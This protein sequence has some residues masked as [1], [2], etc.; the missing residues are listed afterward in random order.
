MNRNRKG[1]QS[2]QTTIRAWTYDQARNALP[3][4]GS[5][6]SS[7]R[8]HWLDAQHFDRKL[9]QLTRQPGRPDRKRILSQEDTR[10]QAREALEAFRNAQEELNELDVFCTDPVRGE[11]VIPF[12]HDKELAWF[13][14][15][16]YDPEPLRFW[17]MH[18]DSLDTRRPIA[19]LVIPSADKPRVA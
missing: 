10:Q 15:D 11:A 8:E 17:R 19:E 7:V 3:Y 6:M 14:Y 12:S 5:V 9:Q 13:I 16:R 2:Q 4:L 1:K 18:T